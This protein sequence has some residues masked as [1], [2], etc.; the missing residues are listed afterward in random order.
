MT[1]LCLVLSF[2]VLIHAGPA[3]AEQVV[4]LNGGWQLQR[5]ASGERAAL[6]DQWQPV[7]VPG[8]L[9]MSA[10]PYAWYRRSF[11]LPP[12]EAG[13]RVFLAFDGVKFACDV[14]LNGRRVGGHL[15]G[16]EPFETDVTDASRRGG[17]NE[18]LVRVQDVRG[19][20]EGDVPYSPGSTMITALE[21]RVLAPIGS[22]WRSFGIW[23]DVSLRLR[24]EI[25]LDDCAVATSVRE[26]AIRA[27]CELRNLGTEPAE[28]TVAA[29]VTDAAKTALDLGE[30]RLR[31]PAGGTASCA[32]RRSWPDAKLWMPGSPHLYYLETSAGAG[33]RT[34]DSRRTRF[35]FREF[36][37]DGTRLVL[38][39]VPM[40]FLA[41][42]GHPP[43]GGLIG[44]D[45]I[46][47]R[48]EAIRS[49]NCV[50]V[51]LHANVWPRRWYDVADEI[52]LPLIMESAIWCYPRSYALADERFWQ[53]AREHW[54]AIIR[55]H[56]NHPS[57]V[58]Y[59][60]ENEILHCHG[61]SVPGTEKRLG[62][63]GRFV[64]SIDPTRPIMYDGDEDPDGAADVVNLHYPHEFPSHL[65]YPNTCYWLEK[66]TTLEGWPYRPWKWDR[67]KPLY[68]GEFLGLGHAAVSA[69]VFTPLLG[70]EAYRSHAASRMQAKAMLWEM[71]VEAFR[72][73]GVAGT[74]PWTVWESGTFPNPESEAVRRVYA[75]N[76][77]I[78]KGYDTHFYGG[79]KV[80]RTVWL[81]NDTLRPAELTLEWSLAG[82]PQGRKRFSLKPGDQVRTTITLSAPRVHEIT[83]V[84]F[85]LSVTGGG[86]T[87][88]AATRRYTV[89]PHQPPR[90]ELP[91]AASVAVYE[92]DGRIASALRAMG[93]EPAELAD[94]AEAASAGARVLLV[95]PH[96]LDALA[97]DPGR[98][99]VGGGGEAALNS[100]AARGG[101]V[102]VLEQGAYPPDMLP[103]VLTDGA[104]TIGFKRAGRQTLLKGLPDD[105]FKFWRGDNLVA[106]RALARPRG[107]GFR[108]FA[109]AGS[110]GGLDRVLLMEVP[111][112]RG[113]FILSQLLIG[114]KLDSE[115]V[116]REMLARLVRYAAEPAAQRRPIGLVPGRMR[117]DVDL[118]A[119][120]ALFDELAG[121]PDGTDL[122]RYACVLVD[123]TTPKLAELCRALR[124]FVRGG[125]CAVLHGLDAAA[126]D[127]LGDVVP[128]ELT[129]LP[130]SR[131][132][133][134]IVDRDDPVTDGLIN[135]DLYW[136]GGITSGESPRASLTPDVLHGEL[137]RRPPGADE[138]GAI[139]PEAMR[140]LEGQPTI[141]PER[142][143]MA[144]NGAVEADVALPQGG[145]YFFG[146]SGSGTPVAGGYPNVAVWLDDAL[147]GNLTLSGAGTF[148]LQA[149]AAAGRHT[150]RLAFTNDAWD[151]RKGEDR[152]V[153]ID[154]FLYAPA[155]RGA[156]E[157]LL[158]PAGLV[159]LRDGKGFWLI[160][161]VAWEGRTGTGDQAARYLS[162]LLAN[163]GAAF[164]SRAGG[165][166][167]SGSRLE[168]V[169]K[170]GNFACRGETAYLGSNG[171]LGID[172]EFRSA[173]AYRFAVVARGT[174]AEGRYPAVKL[175]LDGRPMGEQELRGP[176]WET[177][178][179]YCPSVTAGVHRL[180]VEFTND[181]WLPEE[182]EDRNLWVHRLVISA[183]PES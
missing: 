60:I 20:I 121:P 45:E 111:H 112:G 104:T 149:P 145:L 96:A 44:R 148:W 175:Y 59:S 48:Y 90:L 158:Q 69:H 100:F 164:E 122:S 80:G 74:C 33:G 29:R 130:I 70:D 30:Q 75:P 151:P 91:G 78:V 168:P 146:L 15:G 84:E 81:Y 87:L 85:A 56:R 160:D 166:S 32:F 133:V 37:T 27:T 4:P 143:H 99:V 71:Q 180:E 153:A 154:R 169:G 102:L 108:V 137:I 51:R 92:R 7:E 147:L 128:G 95:G 182:G 93:A 52:G 170:A 110:A 181:L 134:L 97:D 136:L 178:R 157:P 1:R 109:D 76:A 21:G 131:L 3:R 67:R 162:G 115:P 12:G 105:A 35:G 13:R 156:E 82:R 25:Y 79:S 6:G 68:I 40:R 43:G 183:R 31:V 139:G 173:G 129:V 63:L 118:R 174:R 41:T 135:G 10:E 140:P 161:E 124:P 64:K 22:Q 107:G 113:R 53:N 117:L 26:H 72:A 34:L 9:R 28:V 171:R 179:Y 126:L 116:A 36:W 54:R 106:R 172:V 155:E 177:L 19:V 49:I 86:R 163:L 94:L 46:R 120:G 77:A 123:G 73:L 125:G 61:D 16:W 150:L 159:R 138:C 23:Q 58:I 142:V 132:P 98:P 88:Y 17:P 127:A 62:E 2:F 66:Q 119:V 5:T 103:A 39:G 89:F 8:H 83:P 50:A 24:N 176:G 152:N 57:V 165:T 144:S 47:R 114:E 65:L 11:V 38:N 14:Y 55:S 18:L 42:A 167:I 101:T 141:T